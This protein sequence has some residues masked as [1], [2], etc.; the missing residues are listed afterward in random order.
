MRREK[1][2]VRVVRGY[3]EAIREIEEQ[4]QSGTD[5]TWLRIQRSGKEE[6]SSSHT[7]GLLGLFDKVEQMAPSLGNW[8]RTDVQ[9]SIPRS[10]GIG[11]MFQCRNKAKKRVQC[12]I[13][14]DDIKILNQCILY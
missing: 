7:G 4:L 10:G 14:R 9:E 3:I 13:N 6:R 1:G 8:R 11:K 12:C 2:E 5:K